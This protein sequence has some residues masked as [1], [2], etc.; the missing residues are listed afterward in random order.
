MISIK[1]T[2]RALASHAVVDSGYDNDWYWYKYA[3]GRAQAYRYV[4]ITT[5]ITTWVSPWSYGNFNINFPSNLFTT[6][7]SVAAGGRYNNGIAIF[8][9]RGFDNTGVD[10]MCIANN[11]TPDSNSYYYVQ[12]FGFWK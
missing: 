1:K 8:S 7:I 9:A 3:D 4:P 10:V 5:N 6:V 2:L 12:V 11:G